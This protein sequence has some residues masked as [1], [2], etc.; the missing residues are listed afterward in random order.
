MDASVA[1]RRFADHQEEEKGYGEEQ[2]G[3]A[4]GPERGHAE[5]EADHRDHEGHDRRQVHELVLQVMA[6]KQVAKALFDPA[7]ASPA[8]ARRSRRRL[9]RGGCRPAG[10]GLGLAGPAIAAEAGVRLDLLAAG[11]TEHGRK[12]NQTAPPSVSLSTPA[13]RTRPGAGGERQLI[14]ASAGLR[15]APARTRKETK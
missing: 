7:P 11:A 4:E 10:P 13:Q 9:R 14:V 6:G 8:P 15:T 12:D 2:P 3:D 1:E 5:D